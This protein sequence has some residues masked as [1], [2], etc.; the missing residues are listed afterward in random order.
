MPRAYNFSAGPAAI[1]EPVLLEI[2]R[3]LLNYKG[4]GTSLMEISH[5]SLNFVAIAERAE[6][7]LRRLLRIGEEYFVLFLQGGAS[8]QF[9]M[10]PLNLSQ[11]GDTVEYLNTGAWSTKAIAEA[12]RM[13]TVHVVASSSTDVPEVDSWSRADDAQYFHITSNE[14]ISGVQ[15]DKY[16]IDVGVPL[17]ADMTSDFLTRP[18]NIGDFGDRKSVV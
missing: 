17:V 9:A 12:E 6:A 2:Q 1:P 13:R 16:P 5:R 3:D 10:V 18:V 15:F 14:T 4:S 8:L 7:A 11:A